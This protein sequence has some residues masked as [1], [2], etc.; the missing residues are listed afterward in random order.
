MTLINNTTSTLNL[1][2]NDLFFGVYDGGPVQQMTPAYSGVIAN[3]VQ[4]PQSIQPDTA[5]LALN[6]S[7]VPQSGPVIENSVQLD[8][9]L[10]ARDSETHNSFV[11]YAASPYQMTVT[12]TGGLNASV[13]FT[14]SDA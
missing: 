10:M 1:Y 9:F 5:V 14:L 2:L 11:G 4:V 12:H 6:Y 8:W 3:V 13:T 7:I